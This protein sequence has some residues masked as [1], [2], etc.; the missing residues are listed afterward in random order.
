[1]YCLAYIRGLAHEPCRAITRDKTRYHEP[2]RFLPER[3]FNADGTLN[4]D[5]VEYIFGFGRRYSHESF[6]L[7]LT[8]T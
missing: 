7:Q 2:A 8:L 5:T 1:L 3:F 4:G 6:L